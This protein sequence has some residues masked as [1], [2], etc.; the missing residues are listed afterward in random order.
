VKK[1]KQQ[2]QLCVSMTKHEVRRIIA[3]NAQALGVSTTTALRRVRSGMP[4]Y[5]DV[6]W[7][8]ISMLD[9]MLRAK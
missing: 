6:R 4:Q 5:D 3:K 8:D 7:A 9:T 2:D 1:A